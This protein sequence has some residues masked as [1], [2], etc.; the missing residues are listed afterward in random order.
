[1][2]IF[3]SGTLKGG[4]KN[5]EERLKGERKPKPEISR[6]NDKKRTI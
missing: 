1:V 4:N 5:Q 6:L 3:I 2:Y